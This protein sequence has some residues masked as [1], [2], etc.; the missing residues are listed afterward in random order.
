[1]CWY[2]TSGGSACYASWKEQ[3]NCTYGVE[4]VTETTNTNDLSGGGCF[5]ELGKPSVT[6]PTADG[7]CRTIADAKQN[8]ANWYQ[9]YRRRSFVA[10]AATAEVVDGY[11]GFRYGLSLINDYDDLFVPMLSSDVGGYLNNTATYEDHNEDLVEAFFKYEWQAFGTPLRRG[12]AR[13]GSYYQSGV[14][15]GA[16]VNSPFTDS[17]KY[18]T[19]SPIHHEC[20][21]NFS[22]LF[23][24]GYWNGSIQAPSG[25]TDGDGFSVSL[26]DVARYY[27]ET[28]LRND[29]DDDVPPNDFD[30]AEWQHMVT[31]TVA[32]G[33]EGQLVDS[34]GDGWPNNTTVNGTDFIV[35]ANNDDVPEEDGDWGDA[36]GTSDQSPEKIDDLWHAAFNSREPLSPPRPRQKW[37]QVYKRLSTRL[38]T[39]RP[40]LP[41][42]P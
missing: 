19:D 20:Q 35:D 4:G 16:G 2:T 8:V 14:P 33:V 27:Y 36:P 26:A 13:V 9:Y 17:S 5:R 21:Q 6:D 11:P 12:L 34:D 41:R 30:D 1:M 18:D 10:K 31:F 40:R 3:S 38:R 32:F 23:S 22:L 29:L 7:Y 39:E 37:S 25:D 28:D 24:D 15:S 42:L